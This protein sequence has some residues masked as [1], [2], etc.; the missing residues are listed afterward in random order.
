MKK[1]LIYLIL[2]VTLITGVT[3]IYLYQSENIFESETQI[4][5]NQSE[6]ISNERYFLSQQ[7]LPFTN[8]GSQEIRIIDWVQSVSGRTL[9][10]TNTLRLIRSKQ[11][12]LQKE[13]SSE[14]EFINQLSKKESTGFYLYF[15]C[16]I[17]I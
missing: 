7:D 14:I 3:R 4:T 8:T 2:A 10:E 15:L 6:D 17:L 9:P 11:L 12:A 16:K 13:Y 5:S 1:I